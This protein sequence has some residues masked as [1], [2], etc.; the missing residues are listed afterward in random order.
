MKCQ[1]CGQETPEKKIAMMTSKGVWCV[2]C[3]GGGVDKLFQAKR[4]TR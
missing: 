1:K 4:G 3:V 2:T